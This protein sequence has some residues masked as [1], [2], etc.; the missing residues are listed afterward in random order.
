MLQLAHEGNVLLMN[1]QGD[2]PREKAWQMELFH[3][4]LVIPRID[5]WPI[6]AKLKVLG[7]TLKM[8]GW[9]MLMGLRNPY[10]KPDQVQLHF[11]ILY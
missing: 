6:M 2:L 11:A 4:L 8:F 10:P 7:G 5:D 1:K 9:G 3:W